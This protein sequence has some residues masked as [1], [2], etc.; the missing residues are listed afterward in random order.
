MFMPVLQDNYM[1]N[2]PFQF[3]DSFIPLPLVNSFFAGIPFGS[4]CFTTGLAIWLSSAMSFRVIDK[5]IRGAA[6]CDGSFLSH[7]NI[8]CDQTVALFSEDSHGPNA[9]GWFIGYSSLLFFFAA[10][11]LNNFRFCYAALHVLQLDI[12][13]FLE[14]F[15]KFEAISTVITALF[16]PLCCSMVNFILVRRTL[17]DIFAGWLMIMGLVELTQFLQLI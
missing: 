4:Y 1:V 2:L 13:H 16:L 5:I 7:F 10:I 12:Q 8:L 11:I 17:N 15:I 6:I 3:S 14:L 9:T